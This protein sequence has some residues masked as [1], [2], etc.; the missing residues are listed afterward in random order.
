MRN[1]RTA[2]QHDAYSAAEWLRRADRNGTLDEFLHPS[3]KPGERTVAEVEGW[4][5]DV[6]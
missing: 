1:D 3:L 5:L 2:D 6:R 4:I